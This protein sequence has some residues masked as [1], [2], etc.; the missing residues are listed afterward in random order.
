MLG[1]ING[2]CIYDMG[3]YIY[4]Y[5]IKLYRFVSEILVYISYKISC[6]NKVKGVNISCYEF[7]MYGVF[8]NV[9]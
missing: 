7:N 5:S 1:V 8:F 3:I 2:G 9:K 6:F 4:I